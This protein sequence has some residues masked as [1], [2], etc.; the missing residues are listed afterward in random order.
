VRFVVA[1]LVLTACGGGPRP[2]SAPATAAAPSDLEPL[3]V[4]TL[5]VNA[6]E[7]ASYVITL[8]GIE[9]GQ[10]SFAVGEPGELDGRTQIV[11]RSRADASGLISLVKEL[12]AEGQSTLDAVTGLPI[13]AEGTLSWG[14]RQFRG[15]LA[16]SGSVVDGAWFNAAG[17]IVEGAYRDTYG[18]PVHNVY[19]AM[20]AVRAW[21]GAPGERRELQ[22]HGAVEIWHTE[23]TW[24]G[25]EVIGTARGNVAAVRVDGTCLLHDNQKWAIHVQV[26][27]SDD[28]DRVPLRMDAKVWKFA[29]TFELSDYVRAG[30]ST[31]GDEG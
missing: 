21:D 18:P 7:R 25:R 15:E 27:I 20:A 8:A 1:A 2:A 14:G 30:A 6:G 17:D 31:S 4:V 19:S 29:T 12:G 11:V 10:A 26:W 23:L 24:I 9:L 13:Q 22:L 3:E 16:Y 28:A 5:G